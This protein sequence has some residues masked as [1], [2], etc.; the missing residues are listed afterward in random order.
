VE[1]WLGRI[2]GCS[3]ERGEKDIEYEEP[4]NSAG[5]VTL[6]DTPFWSEKGE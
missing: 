3:V 1:E 5:D 4:K 2:A 6:A